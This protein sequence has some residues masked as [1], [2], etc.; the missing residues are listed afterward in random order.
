MSYQN[1]LDDINSNVIIG[2]YVA[3][4]LKRPGQKR[5][6]WLFGESHEDGKR[7]EENIGEN[8][9]IA[10]IIA[11]YEDAILLYEGDNRSIGCGL[12]ADAPDFIRSI[13]PGQTDV[14]NYAE[15]LLEKSEED[16]IDLDEEG[17]NLRAT[18]EIELDMWQ[19]DS[20]WDQILGEM[21][22]MS[23]VAQRF[24]S[25]GGIGINFDRPIRNYIFNG[26][27]MDDLY[28]GGLDIGGYIT[29]VTWALN[30]LSFSSLS[31]ENVDSDLDVSNLPPIAVAY[32]NAF[33]SYIT[34]KFQKSLDDKVRKDLIVNLRDMLRPSPSKLP[35]FLENGM[36]GDD[37]RY[38]FIVAILMDLNAS[39]KIEFHREKDI[40]VYCGG[41]HTINQVGL[42]LKQGYRVE[43]SYVNMSPNDGISFHRISP[44]DKKELVF[45]YDT[46]L[47]LIQ[48]IMNIEKTIRL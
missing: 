28:P 4:G 33:R 38:L 16:D 2:P 43:H 12:F 46:S 44:S 37:K 18:T 22:D 25:R 48:N 21:G 15:C 5:G 45:S 41:K 23:F 7:T 19:D 35:L 10:D 26:V 42:L 13:I 39:E 32:I 3:I 9:Y 8:A 27:M 30:N 29:S 24:R 34:Y 31:Y 36:Y 20:F 11:K 47:G 14:E 6:I 17:Y 1:I 40:V